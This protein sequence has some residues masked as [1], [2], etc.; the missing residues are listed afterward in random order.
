MKNLNEFVKKE[1]LDLIRFIFP[2]VFY[3]ATTENYDIAISSLNKAECFILTRYDTKIKR[4]DSQ[5]LIEGRTDF[6][7]KIKKHITIFENLANYEIDFNQI[8]IELNNIII[9]KI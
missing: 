4:S 9:D 6:L 7:N 1:T 8:K 5:I 2:D 3:L